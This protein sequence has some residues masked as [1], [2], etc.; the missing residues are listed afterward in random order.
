MIATGIA[1][2]V[3]LS[4][5]PP[6]EAATYTGFDLATVSDGYGYYYTLQANENNPQ[7]TSPLT[8]FAITNTD[9]KNDFRVTSSSLDQPTSNSGGPAAYPSL[10]VGLHWPNDPTKTPPAQN[11]SKSDP[12]GQA[13]G[14][15]YDGGL[16]W[17]LT[18]AGM[19]S[20][21]PDIGTAFSTSNTT[22]APGSV[23]DTAYDIWFNS[24]P[25]GNQ[26]SGTTPTW[27]STVIPGTD[28]EVM[29]WLNSQGMTPAGYNSSLPNNGAIATNVSIEY[30]NWNVYYQSHGAHSR[31]LTFVAAAPTQSIYSVSLTDFASEVLALNNSTHPTIASSWYL[32]DVEAGFEIY[33]GGGPAPGDSA[34]LNGS[35]V[36]TECPGGCNA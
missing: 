14:P 9:G 18:V 3:W 13:G 31:V 6:A 17:W 7:S 29:I 24:S 16:K 22:V 5:A 32:Y 36:F 34:G 21:N 33:K 2:V 23:Y 28:M 19:A 1:A 4:L 27:S 11:P 15:A 20:G 26:L 25:D 10:Y 12:L 30:Q 8:P 35:F